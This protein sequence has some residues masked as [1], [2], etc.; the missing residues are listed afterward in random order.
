MK[1]AV[2]P[3]EIS[4]ISVSTEDFVREVFMN[5]GLDWREHV[6]SDRKL[7]RPSDIDWSQGDASLAKEC[8]GWEARTKMPELV[9]L[10]VDATRTVANT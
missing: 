3:T 2:R 4:S 6:I 1:S 8:L 10:M 9:K 7:F 5:V